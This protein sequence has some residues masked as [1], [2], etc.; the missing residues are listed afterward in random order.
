MADDSVLDDND[1]DGHI[2]DDSLEQS[3]FS[4]E[5]FVDDPNDPSWFPEAK[6]IAEEWIDNWK[7]ISDRM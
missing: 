2:S 6:P 4:D 7:E 1:S 5:D 3:D